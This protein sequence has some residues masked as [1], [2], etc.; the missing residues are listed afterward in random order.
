MYTPTYVIHT[1]FAFM[2][3]GKKKRMSYMPWPVP[4]NL[5]SQFCS[6]LPGQFFKSLLSA[7]WNFLQLGTIV[8]CINFKIVGCQSYAFGEVFSSSSCGV[9]LQNGRGEAARVLGKDGSA[10]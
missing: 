6:F 9:W 2:S 8:S 10:T 5:F 3:W 1:S 7:N 4:S